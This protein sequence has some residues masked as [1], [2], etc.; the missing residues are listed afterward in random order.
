MLGA[1]STLVTAKV[2]LSTCDLPRES[3]TLILKLISEPLAA[4]A[5]ITA[6]S[7]T[8][9]FEPSPSTR[10][11]KLLA[12]PPPTSSYVRL[13]VSSALRS[14]TTSP[15]A[16]FS[17]ISSTASPAVTPEAILSSILLADSFEPTAFAIVG[18]STVI[19]FALPFS[20]ADFTSSASFVPTE[21]NSRVFSKDSAVPSGI[22]STRS[23]TVATP[24]ITDVLT[25]S[26]LF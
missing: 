11:S 22:L 19:A 9:S 13:P 18:L 7:A 16:G 24:A 20:T 23:L 2:K 25:K 15:A 5:S 1:S 6:P 12:A 8:T 10:I 17:A 14:P 3:E 4:S 26:T 21:K